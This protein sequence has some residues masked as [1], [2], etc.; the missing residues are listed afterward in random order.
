MTS[1]NRIVVIGVGGGVSNAVN[2]MIKEGITGVEFVVVDT[3]YQALQWSNAALRIWIGDRTIPNGTHGNS[4]LGRRS[5]EESAEELRSFLKGADMVFIVDGMGDGTGNG[6]LPIVARI[7]KEVGAVTIAIVTK[8]STFEGKRRKIIAEIGINQLKD[9]VNTLIVIPKILDLQ[10]V[11]SRSSSEK[12]FRLAEDLADDVLCQTV[13]GI[14]E[15]VT[16][17][18]LKNVEFKDLCAIMAE[19]GATSVTMGKASGKDRACDAAKRAISSALLEV[20]IYG[21]RNVLVNI[22]GGSDL[23]TSEVNQIVAI[24]KE[25]MSPSANMIFGALQDPNLGDEIH[26]T[27]VA[28]YGLTKAA[29]TTQPI[30]SRSITLCVEKT[31]TP[32][33]LNEEISP[34]LESIAKL[35]HVIDDLQGMP[36]SNVNINSLV[37][38]S[39]SQE[40]ESSLTANDIPVI[41][42]PAIFPYVPPGLHF[43]G[44]DFSSDH[45]TVKHPSDEGDQ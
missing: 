21:A 33:L 5:A 30:E 41:K 20:T 43:P 2:R 40:G 9:Q 1:N 3:D 16:L 28:S 44:Y 31:L 13:Q 38:T 29:T 35:Q 25:T 34:Y 45:H 18:G 26:V 7:A 17:P 27:I 8:P 22:T 10:I 12:A 4:E 23:S 19:G 11:N 37:N 14:T 24:I 39:I 15:I 42:L 36:T 6:A 32:V